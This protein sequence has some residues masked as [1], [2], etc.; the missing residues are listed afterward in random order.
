VAR[1]AVSVPVE[2]GGGVGVEGG[3][4]IEVGGGGGVA[5]GFGDFGGDGDFALAIGLALDAGPG[6]ACGALVLAAG[7]GAPASFAARATGAPERPTAIPKHKGAQFL[8]IRICSH[9]PRVGSNF[10]LP[11]FRD[12]ATPPARA[13][14]RDPQPMFAR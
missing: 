2:V 11:R 7:L 6:G 13:P 1:V 4:G 9:G 8:C 3:V 14:R 12:S 10:R 5:V